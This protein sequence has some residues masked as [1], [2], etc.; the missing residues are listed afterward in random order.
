MD[1][2]QSGRKGG[3]ETL[4][5]HGREH[6]QRLGRRGIRALADRYFNG[7]IAD[8][9]EWLRRRALTLRLDHGVQEKLDQ[10]I[11][12]GARVASEELPV[13][14]EPQEDPSFWRDLARASKEGERDSEIPF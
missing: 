12:N 10:Q 2:K 14:L 7:L 3:Q 6:F 1:P 5:R 13:I 4:K 8:A 9:M 11:A